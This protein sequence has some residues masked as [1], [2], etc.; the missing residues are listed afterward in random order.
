MVMFYKTKFV[1]KEISSLEDTREIFIAVILYFDHVSPTC[2]LGLEVSKAI[3]SHDI[4]AHD[5]ALTCQ[6]LLQKVE[7]LGSNRPDKHSLN[8]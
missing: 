8:F 4:P 7:W 6:V 5:D 2:D 3:F 1:C